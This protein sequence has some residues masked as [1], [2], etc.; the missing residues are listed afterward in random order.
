ML[1]KKIKGATTTTMKIHRILLAP[2]AFHFT[3]AFISQAHNELSFKGWRTSSAL[4]SSFGYPEYSGGLSSSDGPTSGFTYADVS[5]KSLK[6]TDYPASE[7]IYSDFSKSKANS[8][9]SGKAA[10]R[11]SN[12]S[13]DVSYTVSHP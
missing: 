9:V 11:D 5:K 2:F 1:L 8:D 7:F 6:F 12:P 10:K 3:T 13:Y 4:S